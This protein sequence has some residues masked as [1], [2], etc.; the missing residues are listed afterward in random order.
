MKGFRHKVISSP[1]WLRGIVVTILAFGISWI[2]VYDLMS[3]S[4]FSPM[5]KAADFRFSDFYMLVAN[6]RSVKSLHPSIVVVAVDGCNRREIAAALDD[7]DYCMPAAVGLDI[8][9]TEP[10]DTTDDPLADAIASCANLVM[11][12]IADETSSERYTI[13]HSSYYDRFAQQGTTFAAANI[14]GEEK[15]RFTVRDF[16]PVFRAESGDD[17]PSLAYALVAKASP[18]IASAVGRRGGKDEALQY[19]SR[20]FEIIYPEEILGNQESIEGK[21]VIVGKVRDAGDLHA[22]PLDNFTPGVMIHAYA[23]ATMLDGDFTGRLTPFENWLLAAVACYL[24]VLL[25]LKLADS[26][27]DL[28]VRVV[29]LTTLYIMI[30]GGVLAYIRLNVDLDFSNA[31]LMTSLGV[32]ASDLF[33]GIFAD[34]GIIARSPEIIRRILTYISRILIHI[35][36]LKHEIYKKFSLNNLNRGSVNNDNSVTG[37]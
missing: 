20:E 29:Q 24:V 7:I 35:N 14:D 4:F 10:R 13:D 19:S 21:I 34:D 36:R 18:G 11:P 37:A 2:A 12:V 32:V 22:T 30:I 27:G 31:M 8:S 15:A 23:A 26:L 9:F 3:V 5:E 33:N 25:S 1:L 16:M 6:D 17:I 28:I